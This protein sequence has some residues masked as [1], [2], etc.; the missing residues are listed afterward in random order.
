M[1]AWGTK[2]FLTAVLA[3]PT[4]CISSCHILNAHHC[5]LSPNGC[6]NLP[7][8]P[9]L[10]PFALSACLLPIDSIHDITGTEKTILKTS[11]IQIACT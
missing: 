10:P 9:I 6:F 7:S 8:A 11:S 3:H 2:L 1:T 4:H 5:C